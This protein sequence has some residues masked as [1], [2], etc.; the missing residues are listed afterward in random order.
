[1]NQ[2]LHSDH[3]IANGRICHAIF[4][5]LFTAVLCCGLLT[6][7]QAQ[8][9]L[10]IS[11][12]AS[13]TNGLALSWSG[14]SSNTAYTVQ[15]RSSL[16][17]GEW[18]N[19]SMRYRWPWPFTN[20]S[21]APLTLLAPRFYRVM[22]ETL[23][24]PDRGRLLTNSSLGQLSTNQARSIL[25]FAGMS[26][27]N[28][29]FPVSKLKFS[30]ET[31]DPFGLPIRA[32]GLLVV[33]Q[34]APGPLPLVSIQHGSIAL[35]SDAP[36]QSSTIFEYKAGLAFATLG[37][38]AVVPDYL[39]FGDSPGYQS[40][41][42]AQSMATCVVDALRAARTLCAS[43][44]ITLNGQLFLFGYSQGGQAT[45]ATHRELETFHTNEFSVTG[46]APSAGAYDVGGVTVEAILA[47]PSYDNPWYFPIVLASFLPIYN[48]AGTLE[49][50]LAEPYRRTLPRLLDGAHSSGE[51]NDAMPRD[52]FQ[53]LRPDFQADFRTNANN[54]LR[55]AFRDNHLHDWTPQT[56]MKM[57]QC[58]GD[59]D[60]IF[61]N[62][63]VAYQSFIN[64][65]ACCVELVDPGAPQALDHGG[66]VI[67]SFRG[68]LTW[69]E[70]LKH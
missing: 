54:P 45:M 64:R 21:D 2:K 41:I 60:V 46:S 5:P 3:G 17:S 8:T 48:L 24:P 29:K 6:A 18:Q 61:A 12:I 15:F 11:S 62:A 31:V 42:H 65:G 55:L 1:M 36:S 26:F 16:T 27:V 34:G 66:C 19:A 44:Q 37:Y 68:A 67:P 63:Q 59:Q 49:G 32:S 70:T 53:I 28:P 9:S 4:P 22:T 14:E 58:S 69:F 39:G 30:Y 23:P 20:W 56:P 40:Y 50:L 25:L 52:P 51:L 57:L 10:V 7:A 33:P 47:N 13:T 43:N 38:V 35:R